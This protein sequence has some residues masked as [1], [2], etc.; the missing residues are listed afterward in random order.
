MIK[1]LAVAAGSC[2]MV[3]G[4]AVDIESEGRHLLLPE[5]EALHIHKTGAL[6]LSCLRLAACV[7]PRMDPEASAAL[8]RFGKAIGLAFQIQD[9]VLDEESSAEQIGKTPGKDRIHGKSTYVSLMGLP[10]AKQRATEL[11][12]EARSAI[13]IFG[14]RADPLSALCDHIQHRDY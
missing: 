5:L 13:Q 2:G 10:S 6:F 8:E 3:G 7:A 1:V 11:F 9:D 12:E 4:Q 14:N